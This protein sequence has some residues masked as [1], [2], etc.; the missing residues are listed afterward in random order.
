MSYVTMWYVDK[1][2]VLMNVI[3]VMND[4]ITSLSSV[5]VS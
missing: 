3:R 4:A 2:H 5:Y 1:N